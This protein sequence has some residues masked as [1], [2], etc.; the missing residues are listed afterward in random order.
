MP[1]ELF[2]RLDPLVVV[3]DMVGVECAEDPLVALLPSTPAPDEP[4]LLLVPFE[5]GDTGS[6][7]V[8][9]RLASDTAL[10]LDVVVDPLAVLVLG[11]SSD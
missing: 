11:P 6:R 7:R 4:L 3:L 1:A 8:S 9:A 2:S 10:F 5:A